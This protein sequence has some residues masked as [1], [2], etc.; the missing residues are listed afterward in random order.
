MSRG[1]DMASHITG[2]RLIELDDNDHWFFGDAQQSVLNVIKEFFTKDLA[3]PILRGGA[4]EINVVG[5]CES[6]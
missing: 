4:D 5:S 6:D 2:A 3:I 1:R